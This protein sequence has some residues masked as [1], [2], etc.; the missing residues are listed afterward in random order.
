MIA[1]LAA[2][3]LAQEPAQVRRQYR[4]LQLADGRTLYGEVLATRAEGMAIAVPEG[5][6][7]LS[8]ELLQD[9]K[10]IEQAVYDAQPPWVAVV[11]VPPTNRDQITAMLD[12]IPSLVV[13]TAE[14]TVGQPDGPLDL[15][16]A[17]Q[18]ALRG[19]GTNPAC[20]RGAFGQGAG[21]KWVITL[22]AQGG[23]FALE[24]AL[25]GTDTR[26]TATVDNP[27]DPAV[28]L[29]LHQV[30][31][32]QPPKVPPPLRASSVVDGG[33]TRGGSSALAFAPVPG[34][35]ALADGDGGRF[36]LALATAIPATAAWVAVVGTHSQS[37]PEHIGLGV[38]GF[39]AITV[40]TNEIFAPD[41]EARRK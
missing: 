34:L 5:E 40:L 22:T 6:L 36:G 20:V 2:S 21:R 29:A 35:P 37:A 32:L 9:M 41:G 24:G 7:V 10:P 38:A 18:A 30:M 3:A 25:T 26:N 11:A 1:W 23:G 19:C 12:A 14:G 17:E 4:E 39:Y 31:G 16:D 28:W 27:S 33:R 8:Y 13:W 15:G